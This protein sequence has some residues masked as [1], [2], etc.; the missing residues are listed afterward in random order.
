[1]L[2]ENTIDVLPDHFVSVQ[3][4]VDGQQALLDWNGAASIS[5]FPGALSVHP[6]CLAFHRDEWLGAVVYLAT[7]SHQKLACF[8]GRVLQ[9]ATTVLPLVEK[10][11]RTV[12]AKTIEIIIVRST[13]EFVN[14]S[15]MCQALLNLPAAPNSDEFINV[16]TQTSPLS[17]N[18]SRGD[19]RF[20]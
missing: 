8:G 7:P 16:G 12:G 14:A 3:A 5:A 6:P 17:L 10:I 13:V 15:A 4:L 11:S 20:L 1:M 18:C 9:P 2:S 19:I